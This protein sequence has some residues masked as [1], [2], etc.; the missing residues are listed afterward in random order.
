MASR[1]P[2]WRISLSNT[3]DWT[4]PIPP[5][6]ASLMPT[7]VVHRLLQQLH[8]QKFLPVYP[9]YTVNCGILYLC[10]QLIWRS[11]PLLTVSSV[12]ALYC[13]MFYLRCPKFVFLEHLNHSI[14]LKAFWYTSRNMVPS[15]GSSY[16]CFHAMFFISPPYRRCACFITVSTTAVTSLNCLQSSLFSRSFSFCSL[17]NSMAR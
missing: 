8:L 13:Q 16:C 12:I 17:S 10:R 6:T 2:F 15:V 4:N 11:S 1:S 9:D 7:A 3:L 5:S 14:L